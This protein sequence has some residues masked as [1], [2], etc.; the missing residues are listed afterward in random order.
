MRRPSRLCIVVLA[1]SVRL[2]LV[3][4]D[5]EKRRLEP[6]CWYA[7]SQINAT[8]NERMYT[9]FRGRESRGW[10]DGS[11]IIRGLHYARVKRGGGVTGEG[12]GEFIVSA[13]SAVG[14]SP[15]LLSPILSL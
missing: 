2:V 14:G 12:R 7:P 8:G 4:V 15:L 11:C 6:R 3:L 13:K 9:P 5:H 1:L 10:K